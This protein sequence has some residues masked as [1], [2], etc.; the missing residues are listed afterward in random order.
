MNIKDFDLNSLKVLLVL[1][2]EKNTSKTAE[3][4]NTSQSSV[5]RTLAKLRHQLDDAI[6]V[7]ES[8]SLK[9]TARGELLAKELPKVMASLEN[10]LAEESFDPTDIKKTLRIALNGFLIETY[11]YKLLKAIN[12]SAPNAKL[13]LTNFSTNTTSELLSGRLDAALNYF[14]I[15]VSKELHQV[16]VGTDEFVG[17]CRHQHPLSGTTQ[18]PQDI[19]SHFEVSGL[20]VPEFN[21]YEMALAKLYREWKVSPAFR[22]EQI[23]PLLQLSKDSDTVLVAPFSFYQTLDQN[24]YSYVTPEQT[25]PDAKY[26]GL[27]YNSMHYQSQQAKWLEELMKEVLS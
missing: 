1:L 23:T 26:I 9:L 3:I 18:K 10:T 16:K 13:E 27:V 14:P 17:V 20:I 2:S 15:E 7:R 22:S 21:Q 6:L 4:L 25:K 19:V 5:S 24:V 12:Q 11:G 8:K